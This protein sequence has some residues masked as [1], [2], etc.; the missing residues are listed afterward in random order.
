MCFI[1][2]I[3]SFTADRWSVGLWDFTHEGGIITPELIK[4]ATTEA[5][6]DDIMQYLEV[7][8]IFEDDDDAVYEGMKK[9]MD[10]LH[11]ELGC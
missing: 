1:H 5:G 3:H 9:T 8:T 6:L 2:W 11:K 4:K 7:V 10:Y